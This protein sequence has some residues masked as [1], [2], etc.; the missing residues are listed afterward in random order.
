MKPWLI[1]ALTLVSALAPS[2]SPL[3]HAQDAPDMSPALL[4]IANCEP[5]AGPGAAPTSALHIAGAQDVD[6]R[7]LFGPQ[8][9]LVIAGG[10]AQ[11]LAPGQQFFIRRAVDWGTRKSLGA[12]HAVETTGGLHITAVNETT[13]LAAVD[14]ACDGILSSDFLVP[15]VKPTLTADMTKTDTSGDPDFSAV[16]HVL[17]GN[18]DTYIAGEGD[19]MIADIGAS[20]GA[21]PGARYAVYRDMA[22]AG[23]PLQPIGEAVVV[24]A[25]P[26]SSVV[27]FTLTRDAARSG[28]LLVLRKP[29]RDQ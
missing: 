22:T 11:G 24:K 28:D 20:R 12:L 21:V 14:F 6:P 3:A 10:S 26:D 16:G 2:L 9:T 29:K 18:H 13:A 27:R 17:G 19:F 15:Y 7:E 4:A 1:S 23:L 25:T 8:D 5:V